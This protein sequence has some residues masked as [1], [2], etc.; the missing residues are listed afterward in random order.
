MPLFIPLLSREK[1]PVLES[2]FG[3]KLLLGISSV[4]IKYLIFDLCKLA[5]NQKV[6]FCKVNMATRVVTV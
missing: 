1:A 5:K 3:T 4:R 6:A 2:R